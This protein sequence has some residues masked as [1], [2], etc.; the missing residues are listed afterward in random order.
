MRPFE[1]RTFDK[2]PAL[3]NMCNTCGNDG[4]SSWAH[5]QTASR[6]GRENACRNG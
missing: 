3:F 6:T 2:T 4:S 5:S 1:D